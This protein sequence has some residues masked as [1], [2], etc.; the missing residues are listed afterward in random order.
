MIKIH[1]GGSRTLHQN[2][3]SKVAQVVQASMAAGAAVHVGCAAGADSAVIQAALSDPAKLFVFAQF[4]ESGKG[5]FSGS[6]VQQV[7]KA[8]AADAQVTFLAGGPLSVPFRGR[9]MRRSIAALAGCSFA[10][11]FLAHPYSA[12]SLA[13]A[14]A[15]ATKNIPVYVFPQGFSGQPV[16]LR[17]LPG[18]WR[19]STFAGFPCLEWFAG[20]SF[21]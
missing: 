10:V 5:S 20:K 16:P 13:V 3:F 11:F 21:F 18:A 15:A 8:Q 12:G 4:S 6:A 9:L 7:L 14:A 1:F 19:P 17:S 2:Q